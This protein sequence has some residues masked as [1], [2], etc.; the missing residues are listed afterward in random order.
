[1]SSFSQ[2]TNCLVTATQLS[3]LELDLFNFNK[4]IKVLCLV[5]PSSASSNS[6]KGNCTLYIQ[7]FSLTEEATLQL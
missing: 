1:M 4:K 2:E 6:G 5:S 7:P 3:N